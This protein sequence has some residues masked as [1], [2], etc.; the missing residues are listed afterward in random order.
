MDTPSK[1]NYLIQE[2]VAANRILAAE[3]IVDA[4]G[5]ISA[6]HPEKLDRYLIARAVPPS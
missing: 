1:K 6:L 4:F 5:H 2:I 3:K